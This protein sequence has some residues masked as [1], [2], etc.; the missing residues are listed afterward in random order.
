MRKIIASAIVAVL[1]LSLGLQLLINKPVSSFVGQPD[2]WSTSKAN[3]DLI[4]NLATFNEVFAPFGFSP[5]DYARITAYA[6]QAYMN[7]R[8][9]EFGDVKEGS[10]AFFK[11]VRTLM[12]DPYYHES[13]PKTSDTGLSDRAA[14]RSLAMAADDAY[15]RGWPAEPIRHTSPLEL[16]GDKSLYTWAPPWGNG[17]EMERTWGQL[18]PFRNNTCQAPPPPVKDFEELSTAAANVRNLMQEMAQHENLA[19]LT[20][21]A[22]EY[23]GGDRV[24]TEPVRIWLQIIANAALDAKLAERES[25]TLVATAALAFHDII[26]KV[27]NAKYTYV[28]AHPIVVMGSDRASLVTPAFP[29]YPSEQAAIAQAGADLLDLHVVGTKP[30]IEL[31]GSLISAP[32]TRILRSTRDAVLEFSAVTQMI[33]QAYEFDIPAGAALGSC[34]VKSH[35]REKAPWA[36]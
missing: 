6:S 3:D 16:G 36:N 28:L 27:W 9:E 17:P 13:L 24:V 7:A 18:R 14:A 19:G 23:S 25:D 31:A 1:A 4:G 32:T 5:T 22:H 26:I 11:V 8:Y 30:R 33:G 20:S 2:G 35:L 29:T 12:P 15:D 10:A 34:V 21:L